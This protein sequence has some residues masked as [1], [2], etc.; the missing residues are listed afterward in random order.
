[1]SENRQRV[2]G[3]IG[4]CSSVSADAGA[5][6]L[7]R[8]SECYSLTEGANKQPGGPPHALPSKH[9]CVRISTKKAGILAPPENANELLRQLIPNILLTTVPEDIDFTL[10]SARI[11]TAGL[12]RIGSLVKQGLVHVRATDEL[13]KARYVSEEDEIRVH[14]WPPIGLERWSA[15]VHE[16][17]HAVFDLHRW[18]VPWRVQEMAAFIT[19]GWYV[20]RHGGKYEGIGK[21]ELMMI[22]LAKLIW[23]IRHHD[24]ALASYKK[25]HPNEWKQ[26]AE[27]ALRY[28]YDE[29]EKIVGG[30]YTKE[31]TPGK[32]AEMFHVD[33]IKDK[34]GNVI[35]V[36][37]GKD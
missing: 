32:F 34:D 35:V 9:R 30:A 7:P 2:P 21:P 15:I 25:K 19:E 26:R 13:G 6:R 20:W 17:T 28:A 1:M 3:P 29:L 8:Q 31:Y 36:E 12:H 5:K 23:A 22:Q 18:D 10:G 24:I 16:A 33:G 27:N 14:E 11:T 4:M 37:E